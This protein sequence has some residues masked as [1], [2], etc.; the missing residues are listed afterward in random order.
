MRVFMILAGLVLGLPISVSAMTADELIA[1]NIEARGGLDAIRAIHSLKLTGKLQN[2]SFEADIAELKVP[3]KVRSEF[4]IQGM[5]QIRA[6]DGTL[7]WTIS[8]FGGR[9]RRHRCAQ[10]AHQVCKRQ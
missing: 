8:P 5:T 4:S 6:Y 10:T 1:K 2:G 7:G 9:C 3:G